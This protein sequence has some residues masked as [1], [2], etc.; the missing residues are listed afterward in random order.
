MRKCTHCK[1]PTNNPKFCTKSCAASHNNVKY[2]KRSIE[3]ICLVD[4]CNIL[5]M[6]SRRYR[7][8]K[9][10][11][12]YEAGIKEARGRTIGEYR[13]KLS[14]EGKHPSWVSAH[15]RIFAR[16]WNMAMTK[17]PCHLCGYSKHVEL[18]HKRAVSTFPDN[19]KLRDVNSP[20]NLIQLCRN[21]HWEMD[22]GLLDDKE[23]AMLEKL[24]RP[25]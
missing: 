15:I 7:C 17:L 3:R 21:C 4:G 11:N 13:R 24:A 19:A 14:V 23:M 18:C 22:N 2:P 8:T 1:T 20:H 16:D 6:S 12:D 10:W 9:H 25:E 5:V